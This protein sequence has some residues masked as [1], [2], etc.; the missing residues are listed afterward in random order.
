MLVL[1]SFR[2]CKDHTDSALEKDYRIR[3]FTRNPTATT[4][5]QPFWGHMF[6]YTTSYGSKERICKIFRFCC[7]HG[8]PT[9]RKKKFS[10]CKNRGS[11]DPVPNIRWTLMKLL[12][13]IGHV[14]A[15]CRDDNMRKLFDDVI[16]KLSIDKDRE[17][18]REM[19]NRKADSV[20]EFECFSFDMK[21]FCE[22][23]QL[24]EHAD[25]VAK[26]ASSKIVSR[27]PRFP[28]SVPSP[29]FGNAV[30][31]KKREPEQKKVSLNSARNDD[32]S[33]ENENHPQESRRSIPVLRTPKSQSAPNSR[34][35][36]FKDKRLSLDE[37]NM[38][39]KVF[40]QSGGGHSPQ[41]PS[42]LPRPL[43]CIN[44]ATV[45]SNFNKQKP[46]VSKLPVSR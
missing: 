28:S 44:F 43:S 37:I 45:R 31:R 14:V 10:H 16:L 15:K 4:D 25:L 32:I 20:E 19:A 21:K 12:P 9:Y 5:L 23:A 30:L 22:E 18:S 24:G 38:N 3:T 29:T 33:S 2:R 42:Q 26:P 35:G 8:T 27:I 7:W 1:I 40:V 41:K 13:K 34:Q 11:D 6:K 46:N 39:Q 36:S 17:I